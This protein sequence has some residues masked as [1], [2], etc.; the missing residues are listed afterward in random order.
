MMRTGSQSSVTWW[1]AGL[2]AGLCLVYGAMAF[3]L[4]SLPRVMNAERASPLINGLGFWR[5]VVALPLPRDDLVFAVIVVGAAVAAPAGYLAALLLVW[6][7]PATRGA[8][9]TVVGFS[10]LFWLAFVLALPDITGDIYVYLAYQRVW[11]LHEANPYLVAPASFPSDP[12]LLYSSGARLVTPYAPVW[13]YLNLGLGKLVGGDIVLGVLGHRVLFLVCC[14]ASLGIIWRI[15]SRLDPARRLTGLVLFAWNPVVASKATE[16][17]E[18]VMVALMLLGVYLASDHRERL[19][20]LSLTLSALIKLVTAPLLVSHILS[21]WFR[22][23]R[24][25]AVWITAFAFIV[26]VLAFAPVWTGWEMLWRL[27]KDPL[28]PTYEGLFSARR[29]AVAVG[30][31]ALIVWT[32]WRGRDNLSVQLRGWCLITLCFSVF[33]V[34]RGLIYYLVT[35]CGVAAIVDSGWIVAAVVSLSCGSW[36]RFMLFDQGRGLVSDWS[37]LDRPIQ[38]APLGLVLLVLAWQRRGM[39]GHVK[40]Y[41]ASTA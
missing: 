40:V 25:P 28:S 38:Y 11:L 27:T 8:I 15:L 5:S 18:A 30:L 10:V 13:T 7:R 21:V 9:I 14:L 31:L 12:I 23:W 22:G 41:S 39:I 2:G 32:S 35:L 3:L 37:V 19:A 29:L 20:V 24:G 34:P 17:T 6:R 33:L 36:L 16:H 26:V 1:L 4:P